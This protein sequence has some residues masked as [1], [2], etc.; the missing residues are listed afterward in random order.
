MVGAC[1]PIYLGMGGRSTGLEWACGRCHKAKRSQELAIAC[2]MMRQSPEAAEREAE[3][4]EDTEPFE[5]D[6]H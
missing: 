2:C 3:Q 1:E 4:I 6:I 5:D